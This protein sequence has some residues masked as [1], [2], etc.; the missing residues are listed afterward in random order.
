MNECPCKEC[1]V[2]PRCKN[3]LYLDAVEKCQLLTNYLYEENSIPEY[4]YRRPDF[5]TRIRIL[6]NIMKPDAWYIDS[7]SNILAK[8]RFKG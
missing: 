6:Q 1:L 4:S 7:L 2:R 8:G 3:K 5:Y